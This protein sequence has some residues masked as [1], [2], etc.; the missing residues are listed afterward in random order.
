MQH[1]E[2]AVELIV[3]D[4]IDYYDLKSSKSFRE[5]LKEFSGSDE[6]VNII[7]YNRQ[8]HYSYT[9]YEIYTKGKL[10]FTYSGRIK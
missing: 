2:N 5:L 10:D 9:G 1:K 4:S 3:T 8:D 7:I 6:N